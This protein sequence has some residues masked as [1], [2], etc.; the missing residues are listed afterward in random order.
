[1]R[2]L[3]APLSLLLAGILAGCSQG[4]AD[5]SREFAEPLAAG[6]DHPVTIHQPPT[7][8]LV[9]TDRTDIHGTPIGVAC[10]TCHAAG[11]DA[12]AIATD[13][14]NPE[15]M[16]GSVDVKHGDLP[17]ASCHDAQRDLL[18]LADGT[19]LAMTAAME[20]CAQCHGTQRRDYDAGAH[21]GMTGYWDLQAGPRTRNHCLD[22]HDAHAPAFQGGAAVHPPKDRFMKKGQHHE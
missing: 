9:D 15:G 8:G 3:L 16:H 10:A 13:L 18:H 2:P 6:P 5:P 1:M 19:Q 17:C 20:L 12:E 21:G 22:C 4:F 11:E 14:G 7:L